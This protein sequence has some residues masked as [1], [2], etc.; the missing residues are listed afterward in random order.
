MWRSVT[1]NVSFRK[2]LEKERL[3]VITFSSLSEFDPFGPVV[4]GKYRRVGG[5]FYCIPILVWVVS[6]DLTGRGRHALWAQKRRGVTIRLIIFMSRIHRNDDFFALRTT[7]QHVLTWCPVLIINP[8]IYF[9]HF[10]FLIKTWWLHYPQCISAAVNWEICLGYAGVAVMQP[11]ADNAA[12][13]SMC[14]SFFL[15]SVVISCVFIVT[16]GFMQQLSQSETNFSFQRH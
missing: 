5:L 7:E 15:L 13:P 6:R 8:L 9:T 12:F 10:F 1:R 11:W 4:F 3:E 14:L 2:S 16:F